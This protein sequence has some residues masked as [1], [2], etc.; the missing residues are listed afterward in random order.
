[1]SIAERVRSQFQR[2]PAGN[3]ITSRALHRLSADS[4]QVDKA[5]SRLYKSEGLEKIR[6]GLYYRPYNSKYFGPLPPKEDVI[7]RSIKQQYRAKIA[8]SGALAAYELGLTHVLPDAITYDT[9]KRIAP[10]TLP[11]H[12]IYFRKIDGKKLSSAPGELLNLLKALAFLFKENDLN[13]FQKKRAARMLDH[14]TPEQINKALTYWPLWFR[15]KIHTLIKPPG[16]RYITGLSA[17]NIPYQGT[18]ADWHQVGMLHSNKFHIAGDNYDSAPDLSSDELFDCT[19]FLKKHDIDVA[20]TRCA[21]PLRAIKDILYTHCIKKQRYPRF[22]KLDQFMFDVPV[23]AI[24]KAV[25]G[26]KQIANSKQQQLLHRWA[27]ENEL[28]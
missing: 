18:Q 8:P 12:T 23:A 6:N 13:I 3:A 4:L 14:Y 1:M 26:L 25:G 17:L 2:L 10:I 19:D 24:K 16:E 9:D 20:T 11:N 5:A 15:D 28:N 7:I 22:F 27:E 21:K